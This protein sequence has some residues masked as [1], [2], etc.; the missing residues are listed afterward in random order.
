MNL[1][2]LLVLWAGLAQADAVLDDVRVFAGSGHARVLLVLQGEPS[3]ISARSSP[4][5]GASPARGVVLMART[6]PGEGGDRVV[7]VNE[8]GLQR[9]RLTAVGDALQLS[10]DLDQARAIRVEALGPSA[11]LVDLLVDG[12]E[13]DLTLPSAPDLQQWVE[14]VSLVRAAGGPPTDR[15]RVMLDP[16]HGGWDHGAVGLTGTREA[17][18][19][20]Q[21]ALLTR[22]EILRRDDTVEVLLTR[23]TDVFV[24]LRDRAALA[25]RADADLFLSIHV[26]AAPGPTA[27]GLE[28]YALDTA[29]DAGAARVAARENTLARKL[30]GGEGTEP[31]LARLLVTGMNQLSRDLAAEVQSHAVR[32]LRLAYGDE[33]IRDLGSKTALFTVLVATRMPAVLYESGFLTNAEEERR[34]RSPQ[35]QRLTADALSDAVLA[36]LERGE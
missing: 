4:P 24:G 8:G 2:L 15:H 12:A 29:S 33:P 1:L 35:Y 13:P 17:D 23:D 7:P 9:L 26:N 6:G 25:N 16:G 11:V 19:A 34:L 28:T 30:G 36:F 32:G 22:A 3:E 10:V 5:V 27:W 31:L 20:L 18:V 14:G 21:L